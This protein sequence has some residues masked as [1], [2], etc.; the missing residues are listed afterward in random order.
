MRTPNKVLS[1]AALAALVVLQAAFAW[2]A[3]LCWLAQAKAKTPDEKIR[4][5]ERAEAV[6]PWNGAVP[7]GLGQAYFAQGAEA[8]GDPAKRDDL[9]RKSIASYLRSLRLDPGSADAHF[10]FGQALLYAGYAGLPTP[11]AYF[12]EYKR[13]AALTGHKSQIRYDAGKV[14]FDHWD[15]LSPEERDFA[16]GLLKST[17]AADT[18]G[19][20]PDMLET[21][22][23]AGHDRGLIE[24]ILHEDAA[25]LTAY[26]RFLG[27]HGLSLED[28]Q[29][30]LARAEALE[31]AR[32][33][34]E[35]EESRRAAELD[36]PAESA[37]RS[38]VAIRALGS[39]K[40][41][42][43]LTGRELFDPREFKA[44]LAS[45]R[46]LRAQSWIE[47]TGSLD[48]P[49]GILAAYLEVE[50]D[51]AALAG[52]E[53]FLRDNHLLDISYADTPFKSLKTLAFRMG[54]AYKLG[55]YADVTGVE[56]L[57][58][59]SST[60]LAPSGRPNYVRILGLIG[61]VNL[62]LNNAIEAK[63]F[64]E[65][66][67][68]VGGPSLDILVGLERCYESLDDRAK[69]AETRQAVER[70]T[71]PKELVLGGQTVSK[72]QT[73]RFDLVM[74]GGP[75][76]FR[77]E[78]GPSEAGEIPLVSVFLDGRVVWEK[79]GDTGFAEFTGTV[80]Q[81][82]ARLEIAAVNAPVVL[83]RLKTAAPEPPK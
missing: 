36:M 15:S 46:R 42:Q 31:V 49:E 29:A 69:A 52:F 8:M 16:A 37:H 43:A 23:L 81:G 74:T 76:A 58:A 66:A 26:A 56:A 57:L 35:I 20:V 53:T 59:S 83:A 6:F 4:L 40:L 71:T 73:V 2:N 68:E 80:K 70:L 30:A 79:Y 63:A 28:R 3:R 47:E 51:P 32:A 5:L 82:E 67:L 45:A 19:R 1:L 50:D 27:E 72:G 12:T 24:R 78:F 65:K 9:F 34:S 54:L 77:L 44:L 75:K 64:F 38:A 60:V 13:A 25:A 41:Y 48:D 21:W 39:V 14:L 62:K 17:M 33:K 10:E 11:L 55:H 61:E 18:Q 7:F 22:Y